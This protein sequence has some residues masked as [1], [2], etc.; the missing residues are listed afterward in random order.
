[1]VLSIKEVFEMAVKE[2]ND[3]GGI[4]GKKIK[5]IIEDDGGK[6]ANSLSATNKLIDINN[7]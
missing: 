7:H 1:M 4:D 6:V 3:K 2:I 5:L